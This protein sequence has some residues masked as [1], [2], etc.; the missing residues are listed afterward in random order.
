M[1]EP[2]LKSI[3]AQTETGSYLSNMF[4]LIHPQWSLEKPAPHVCL[5]MTRVENPDDRI[6][7]HILLGAY[8]V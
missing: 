5:C 2:S 4:T 3:S 7:T 8:N 1:E 6:K